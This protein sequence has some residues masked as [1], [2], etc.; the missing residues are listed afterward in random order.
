MAAS[1]NNPTSAT[2]TFA[3]VSDLTFQSA[4]SMTAVEGIVPGSMLIPWAEPLE[5]SLTLPSAAP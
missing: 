1:V 4:T 5:A 2:L 3:A